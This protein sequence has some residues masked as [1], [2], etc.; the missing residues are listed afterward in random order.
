M[1]AGLSLW[2]FHGGREANAVPFGGWGNCFQF[3]MNCF[4]CSYPLIVGKK[5][6]A[7][8]QARRANRDSAGGRRFSALDLSDGVVIDGQKSSA[9]S[10]RLFRCE[11]GRANFLRG[12][13]ALVLLIFNTSDKHARLAARRR[14]TVNLA[15]GF[16]LSRRVFGPSWIFFRGESRGER[17]E[18]GGQMSAGI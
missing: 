4:S 7:L 16:E 5:S 3:L 12:V 18:I 8:A 1:G 14:F 6:G 11:P 9:T 17:G 10:D 15:N 13:V 2:G